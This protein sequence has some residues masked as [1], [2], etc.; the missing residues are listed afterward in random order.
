MSKKKVKPQLRFPVIIISLLAILPVVLIIFLTVW[1][2]L[3]ARI[4]PNISVAGVDIGLLTREQA[5]QKVTTEVTKRSSRP[6]EMELN[7]NSPEKQIFI[8]ELNKQETTPDIEKA[9]SLAYELGRKKAFFPRAKVDIGFDISLPVKKQIENIAQTL[10]QPPIDSTLKV[11][12]GEITVTPSQNGTILDEQQMYLKINDYLNGASLSN[13]NLPLKTQPP[14]LSFAQAAAIKKRLDVIKNSPVKLTFEDFSFTL[15]LETVLSLVDLENS[16]N[17]L[18]LFDINNQKYNIASI[19]LNGKEISDS[20]LTLNQT[21]LK[22]YLEKLAIQ[23]DRPVQEPLFSIEPSSNPEKP[24]IT[25]FRPPVDGRQLQ[26]EETVSQINSALIARNQTEV[27]LPVKIIQPKNKLSNELGIKELIGSGVS[28]FAGSIENRKFNIGLAASR[29][30]G[31]LVGPDEEFSFVNT[32]GDISANSGYRQA[33]IIKSGRTVLDDGGGVCQVS[34]TVFRAALN[35]GLPITAR[36]AHAYRVGYYEQGF[37]PGLDATIFT[38]S[39]DLKF[40]NDT[41]HHILVQTKVIGTSLYIDLYGTSDG[42]TVE[43]TKPVI[44]SVTPAPPEIRQEDP[45]LPKGTVKQVDFAAAGANV[46]SKRTVTKGGITY[47]NETIK[48]NF[49][50]WQA[51]F[52][53]GTKEG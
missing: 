3:S 6:L 18:A 29:I 32:V 34:T 40:K 28:H 39:V 14:N 25:E 19:T 41:G 10:N 44:T 4:Y 50:P 47:I 30:N 43:M 35:S 5:L 8:I 15:D 49:R 22:S 42:R 16:Q 45:S 27:K 20:K 21:K 37:P 53:V 13:L 52:L 11:Y 31:V 51:V 48:S 7:N 2:F 46:S 36:T 12:E 17:S 1:L 26:I 9:V 23:I 33:Y 24:K 38:P